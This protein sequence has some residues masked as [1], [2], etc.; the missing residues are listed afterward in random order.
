MR[1]P[2]TF[3]SIQLL[4]AVAATLVVLFHTQKAFAEK[5]SAPLFEQESYLFAFGAVGVHI[6][7][8][9]SGFI[10]VITSCAPGRPYS[11]S[12]FFQRRFLRI[13]PIYWLCALVYVGVHGVI[14]QPYNVT[15]DNFLGALLLWPEDSA[16]LIGPAWTLSFEMYFY[17]C[18]GL[19][20]TL[21]FPRGLIVLGAGFLTAIALGQLFPS[22]GILMSLVTNT[23]LLEF[24]AGA[25]IGWLAHAGRLPL[26]WGS[27]LTGLGV[28]LFVAGIAFGFHRLP[29][30]ISWG[31]PSAVL[32]LGLVAW[33]MRDGAA[34]AV[35][36]LGKL[37]DSSYVLYLIHVLVITL[38]VLLCQALG[39]AP[40]PPFAG[41]IIALFAIALAEVVH[42]GLEVPL[43][44]H[45][46]ELFSVSRKRSPQP[47]KLP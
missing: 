37:G 1:Q 16:R 24:L 14:G 42:R 31:V 2:V 27:A 32:V 35:R 36:W 3:H 44:R 19:A 41:G 10:M 17:I 39:L 28:A 4:R 43:L 29:T 25:A 45:G 47:S 26:R 15:P 22:R 46:S 12:R 8:V 38:A 11:A 13:Y 7:F 21:S 23:L 6:F 5:V 30:A 33:E 9:I 34:P 20:M 18:F 40:A